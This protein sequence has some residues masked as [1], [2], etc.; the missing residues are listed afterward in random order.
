MLIQVNDIRKQYGKKT[1]LDGVSFE[2][3]SGKI[4]GVL[5][6]NGS[7]KSTLFSI[8]AGV[9]G[10]N[11][12]SFVCDGVDL[13]KNEAARS[14]LL[15]YVPQGTPLIEELSSRDNLL[16]WYGKEEMKRELDSGVLGMLGIDAFLD[17]RVS[18]L[19]GGMKKRLSIG[20]CVANK[21]KILLLDEPSSALDLVCKERISNYLRAFRDDGGIILIA[22][23]DVQ[24][25]GLC[26]EIKLIRNGKMTDVGYDGNVHRLVG[27]LG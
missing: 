7:G 2:A 24:E 11:G 8:L 19:S 22:T 13:F 25:I 21:P 9:I 20:C 27:L 15:G 1:V 10:R 14:A 23:H 26:D 16:L 12:G 3:G 5:G 17:K 4:I 18:E 6:V